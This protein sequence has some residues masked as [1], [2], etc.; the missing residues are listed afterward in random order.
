MSE[1]GHPDAAAQ[2]AAA[3]MPPPVAPRDPM[4]DPD[5]SST[6]QTYAALMHLSILSLAIVPIPLLAAFIMWRAWRDRS[7]FLNDH[8]REALNFQV[9]LAIYVLGAILLQVVCIGP[10]VAIAVAGLGLVGVILA[11]AAS[12]KGRFFRYPA[13]IRLIH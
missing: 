10:V 8:G 1:A 13:C 7:P 2:P 4:V 5:A 12:L 9:S 6:E 3:A 11:T